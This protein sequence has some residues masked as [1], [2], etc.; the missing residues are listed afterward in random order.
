MADTTSRALRLLSLLQSRRVWTGPELMSR[1]EVSERTLRRDIDRLRELGY[2]VVSMSG[3]A[4]GYQLEAGTDIPPLLLDD[5]EAMAIA[6]SLLTA[7]G[8][9]VQGLE[10]TSVRALTKLEQVLPP[11]LRQK[12]STL[13]TAVV[14]L[15]RSW[16][17]VDPAILTTVAQACRDHERL[18]FQYTTRLG[19][20]TERH[21][22]PHQLVSIGQRWYLLAY[23]RDREDWRT[24][25]L[26]RIAEPWRTRMRFQPRPIPG[27]SAAD[28]VEQ[29]LRSMPMRYQVAATIHAP[30]EDVSARIR[31]GEGRVEPIDDRTCVLHLQSDV[32]E[33]IVF[34]LIWL[35]ADFEVTEPAELV[36]FLAT[37]NDRLAHSVAGG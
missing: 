2:E 5:E 23:D 30:A 13:S 22:E 35:G 29:S 31:H 18:R 28:Y 27:G 16:V 25:R 20:S 9:S 4:G 12:V 37:L 7:A 1:L 6:V 10:E 32:L 14:P 26:D 8:G 3:P 19:D 36:E 17:T 11:R 34:T 15:V 33:W 21:V 24:F